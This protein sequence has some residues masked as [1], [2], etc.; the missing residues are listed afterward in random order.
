MA[1]GIFVIRSGVLL[2]TVLALGCYRDEMPE[3]QVLPEE[4]DSEELR[5]QRAG[6]TIGSRAVTWDR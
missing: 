1:R 4:Y 5:K 2:C 6:T 3:E